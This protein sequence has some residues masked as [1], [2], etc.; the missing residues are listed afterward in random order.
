MNI[1]KF[2]TCY[3]EYLSLYVNI[4]IVL[5]IEYLKKLNLK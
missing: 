1:R 3:R 5:K 2:I 4:N